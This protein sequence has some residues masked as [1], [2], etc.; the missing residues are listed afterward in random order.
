MLLEARGITKR[1]GG[2]VALN[3]VNVDV[4]EDEILGIIGP[5]GSGKTTLFNVISG[6][7]KPDEGN[8]I[9]MGKDITGRPPHI[10]AR[11]GIA[12]TFQV[13]RPFPSMTV[14]ENILI[15]AYFS[16]NHKS[17]SYIDMLVDKILKLTEL[18][19]KADLP[20]GALNLPGKRRLEI[21]RALAL[22]PKLLLLDETLAG[23]TPTEI[24]HALEM[25]KKAKSEMG[26]T[27]IIVEHIMRAIMK[28]SDRIIVFS[29]GMKIAEG[30]PSQVA[31]DI[32]VIEAYLGKPIQGGG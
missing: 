21:A 28:I 3:K 12:R 14:R 31:S 11:M 17:S 22:E 26:L 2:V 9:F 15:G 13:V 29:N 23:L 20:A 32:K 6:I 7:Y 18:S 4:A 24:D 8:V 16:G 19:S 30:T 5:N 27:I 25:I 10:I 1:F